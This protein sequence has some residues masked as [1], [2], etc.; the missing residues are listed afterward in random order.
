MTPPRKLVESKWQQLPHNKPSQ[1]RVQTMPLGQLRLLERDRPDAN[2]G[3]GRYAGENPCV[4]PWRRIWGDT[5]P[6]M[7]DCRLRKLVV[8]CA[9]TCNSCRCGPFLERRSN[10][11]ESYFPVTGLNQPITQC[12]GRLAP[13]IGDIPK[14]NWRASS[15]FSQLLSGDFCNFKVFSNG[16]A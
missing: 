16:H 13:P 5:T 9:L 14:P 7:V 10:A 12:K 2:A 4:E 6:K 3:L 11:F 15:L 1:R 8:V